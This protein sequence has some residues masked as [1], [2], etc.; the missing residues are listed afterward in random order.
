MQR[1]LWK[2]GHPDGRVGQIHIA[3][4]KDGAVGLGTIRRK[5]RRQH[6]VRRAVSGRQKRYVRRLHRR[7]SLLAEVRSSM[8]LGSFDD[9]RR[10]YVIITP[11]TPLP[12]INYLGT[13]DFFSLISHQAGGYCFYKDA[14]LRRI[15]RYRYNN[16]PTDIGGRY[17]Y[18]RDGADVWS[19]SYMP[20]KAPLDWFECR[21][22]LGYT[23]IGARRCGVRADLLF[24][25]P[26]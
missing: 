21:H 4:C 20:V 10:E 18:I 26:L 14:R 11:H 24:L 12:W 17:F 19:P 7:S 9:A 6:P 25:V 5:I 2:P 1:P 16:V 23:A 8:S 22:G 3:L 13:E 15:L